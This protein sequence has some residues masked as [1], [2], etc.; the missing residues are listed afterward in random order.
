M[1]GVTESVQTSVKAVLAMAPWGLIVAGSL[2]IGFLLL[3]AVLPSWCPFSPIRPGIFT[4]G[5]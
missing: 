4:A 5:S 2:A 1:T 3:F